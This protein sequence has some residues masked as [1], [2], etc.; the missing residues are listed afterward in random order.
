MSRHRNFT[1]GDQAAVTRNSSGFNPWAG[2]CGREGTK[3]A[4]QRRQQ[5][6]ARCPSG[7]SE[8]EPP[9]HFSDDSSDSEE[10]EME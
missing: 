10:V 6:S 9:S 1:T 8:K 5:R 2:T 4:F 3:V 7:S